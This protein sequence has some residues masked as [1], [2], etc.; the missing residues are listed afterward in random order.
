MARKTKAEA[1]QTRTRILKTALTLFVE[2]GYER[3]TF[4]DIAKRI[5]LTKGAVYWHFKNKPDLLA[6]LL[7]KMIEEHNERIKGKLP[8][9][10]TLEGL[11]DHFVARAEWTLNAPDKRKFFRM[12]QQLDW[13]A[14]KFVP[15]RQRLQELQ[16]NICNTIGDAL[17]TFQARGEVRAE[18][19]VRTVAFVLGAMWLGLLKAKADNLLEVDFAKAIATGFDMAFCAI[20]T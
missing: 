12:M 14:R 7:V 1:E 3:T 18:T 11:R 4:E 17:E 5:R 9:P 16:P 20:R 2:K 19:D 15:V 13:G 10:S 6:A 8:E